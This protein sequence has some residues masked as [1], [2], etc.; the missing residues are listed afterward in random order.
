[1]QREIPSM[2]EGG[3]GEARTSFWLETP[4]PTLFTPK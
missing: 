2:G 3:L 1:M 4:A